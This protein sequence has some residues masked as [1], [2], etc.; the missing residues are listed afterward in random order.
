[1]SGTTTWHRGC[2]QVD[3]VTIPCLQ[4]VHS[5]R[6]TASVRVKEEGMFKKKQ[7]LHVSSSSAVAAGSVLSLDFAPGK[8]ESQVR[9]PTVLPG[10][11]DPCPLLPG[12]P[13]LAHHKL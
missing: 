12:V 6:P 11:V 5:R 7:M 9:L 1:M 13:L 8:L 3:V 2:C 4:I 10:Q